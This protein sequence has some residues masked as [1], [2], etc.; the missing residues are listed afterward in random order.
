[1]PGAD[2]RTGRFLWRVAW[3][4]AATVQERIRVKRVR[5]FIGWLAFGS[6]VS[7]V[8][9]VA[10]CNPPKSTPPP[11][12]P[13]QVVIPEQPRPPLG[14]PAGMHIPPINAAGVRQTVNVG[15]GPDQ[16]LWNFRSAYNV[17]A[18]DCVSAQHAAILDNYKLFL[19]THAKR[20]ALANKG[21]DRQFNVASGKPAIHAREAY[22]T[23]VYNFYALPPTLPAFC[24]AALAMSIESTSVPV[25]GIDD[26]A[27]ASLPKLDRVFL[28]FF[29]SYDQY[30]TDL[31][32]WQG[33]YAP[34]VAPMTATVGTSGP[35]PN[36]PAAGSPMPA[37]NGGAYKP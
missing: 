35:V 12:P 32:A 15:I 1:M 2:C 20:L 13:A 23:Q 37:A 7:L 8:A 31:A 11:P 22:M 33:R 4:E 34:V 21:V 9:L 25:S 27:A 6:A 3:L 5:R 28:D 24:D 18:L 16:L 14:A 17:A 36:G 29:N 26:F 30:R 19:K 10:G